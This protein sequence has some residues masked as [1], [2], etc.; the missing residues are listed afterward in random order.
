MYARQKSI[1][2]KFTVVIPYKN[3][4]LEVAVDKLY[5][6]NICQTNEEKKNH[7]IT[8]DQIGFYN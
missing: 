6:S 2:K 5:I 8:N 1:T 4:Y 7:G 3:N